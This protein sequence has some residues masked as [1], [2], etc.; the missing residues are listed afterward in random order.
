[1]DYSKKNL[2]KSWDLLEKAVENLMEGEDMLTI[3]IDR[4]GRK[5]NK[6]DVLLVTLKGQQVLYDIMETEDGELSLVEIESRP[7]PI[8]EVTNA[9]TVNQA[10]IDVDDMVWKIGGNGEHLEL[11]N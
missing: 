11:V 5:E 1:M 2:F 3:M 4:I 7:K 9:Q 10:S 6:P 8:E